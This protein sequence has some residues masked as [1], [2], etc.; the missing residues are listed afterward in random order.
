MQSTDLGYLG[1][2]AYNLASA[3]MVCWDMQHAILQM[4]E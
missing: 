1:T 3:G 2:E 4:S